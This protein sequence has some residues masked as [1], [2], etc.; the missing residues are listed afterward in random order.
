[1]PL[2]EYETIDRK[3]LDTFYR[4]CGREVTLAYTVLNQT[5]TW[6]V[7]FFA[8]VMG[9]LIG[10][11]KAIPGTEDYAFAYPNPYYWLYLILGWGLLLRFLQ[12]SAL[13]LA[14]MY[15]WN[16]LATATWEIAALPAD[17]PKAAILNDRLVELVDRLMIRWRDPRPPTQIF[18]STLKLMYLAPMLVLLGFIVWGLVTLPKTNLYHV[19]LVS[20]VLWTLFEGVLIAS[21]NRNTRQA[22]R[23]PEAS[24]F[25]KL[26]RRPPCEHEGVKQSENK[27]AMHPLASFLFSL[28]R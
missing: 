13:A 27:A 25:L 22:L 6:A 15:R 11:V 21:W 14:N 19:G 2:G 4:E 26:F 23:G 1:M 28:F 17:H 24:E 10:L 7:T 16:L 8:A 9:P 3:F 5:N 12:R 20:F 18:W